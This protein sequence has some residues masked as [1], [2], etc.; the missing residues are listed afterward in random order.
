MLIIRIVNDATGDDVVA[1]YDAAVEITVR[2]PR[3]DG[4]YTIG[5]EVIA[6]GRIENHRRGDGWRVL[7]RR[8]AD[9]L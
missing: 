4:S 7:L 3:A 6:A 1:H 9:E 8:V 5:N 2:R